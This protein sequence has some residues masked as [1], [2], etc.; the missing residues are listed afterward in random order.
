MSQLSIKP[1]MSVR[2]SQ[3]IFI[4][5]LV[6][7]S[8]RFRFKESQSVQISVTLW[9]HP[10]ICQSSNEGCVNQVTAI[11]SWSFLQTWKQ[12]QAECGDFVYFCYFLLPTC[13]YRLKIPMVSFLSF[14]FYWKLLVFHVGNTISIML[15]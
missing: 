10:N 5:H 11:P 3:T 9:W 8:F 13:H 15:P 6:F 2:Q 14:N 1:L 7:H 12:L 4:C